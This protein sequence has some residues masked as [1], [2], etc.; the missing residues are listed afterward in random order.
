[1]CWSAS[2]VNPLAL[3]V[4]DPIRL[5]LQKLVVISLILEQPRPILV[6]LKLTGI[7]VVIGSG[8][9][10]I[11]LLHLHV[12][13]L[14]ALREFDKLSLQCLAYRYLAYPRLCL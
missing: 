9:P 10:L 1:M 13:L 3:K 11:L 14:F 12:M 5:W 7:C 8:T 2:K 6:L 4:E